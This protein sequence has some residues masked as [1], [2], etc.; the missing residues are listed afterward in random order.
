MRLRKEVLPFWAIDIVLVCV[1]W[2]AAFWLRFNFEIPDDFVAMALSSTRWML[3]C[4]IVGLAIARVYRQVWR[5][6]GLPELRQLGWGVLLSGVM[7]ATVILMLRVPFFPRSVLILHPLLVLVMLGA[8]RAGWRTLTEHNAP[9]DS[10][11]PLLIVGSLKDAADALRALKG[12]TQWHCVG[13]ASP[14]EAEQG[15]YLNQIPVLGLS[16]SV[17]DISKSTGATTALIA[18]PPG[19]EDRR[20]VLL[21]SSQA[22]PSRSLHTWASASSPS[23]P[24]SAPSP[25]SSAS[26]RSQAPS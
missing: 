14:L 11:K 19:S 1:A 2:W 25:S 13:I 15:T 7:A 23:A 4:F 22:S 3:P 12:S 18:S 24:S 8:V 17:V 20:D 6:I 21:Q 16:R 5:Y 10:S 9:S 26:L